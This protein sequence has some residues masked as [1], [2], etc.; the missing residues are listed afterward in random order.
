[1]RPPC[2]LFV[3]AAHA[4]HPLGPPVCTIMSRI[5]TTH[6]LIQDGASH[7]GD[8]R[9]SQGL[10]PGRASQ[11]IPRCVQWGAAG[12]KL[13]CPINTEGRRGSWI[14]PSRYPLLRGHGLHVCAVRR[15][16]FRSVSVSVSVSVSFRFLS[17][18]TMF[19]L[20]PNQ[21]ALHQLVIACSCSAY[22]RIQHGPQFWH[23]R[24]VR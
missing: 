21:Y 20:D 23:V 9:R 18:G 19:R 24:G 7:C 11:S 14:F 12:F 2:C 5:A 15:A 1:M 3:C 10:C 6:V 17:S 13:I 16:P 22:P 4:Y 8:V